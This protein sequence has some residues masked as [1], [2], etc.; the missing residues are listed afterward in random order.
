[1]S[2]VPKY[3]RGTIRELSIEERAAVSGGNSPPP[4]EAIKM[5]TPTWKYLTPTSPASEASLAA[6]IA[7][8]YTVENVG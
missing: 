6:A 2:T 7:A 4:P 1:M 8:G 3:A 5:A